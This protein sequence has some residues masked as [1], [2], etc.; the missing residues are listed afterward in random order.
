MRGPDLS[1]EFLSH[2]HPVAKAFQ[3]ILRPCNVIF[4]PIPGSKVIKLYI[5]YDEGQTSTI[6]FLLYWVDLQEMDIQ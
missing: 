4:G 2:I 1:S 5:A 3:Q 6:F